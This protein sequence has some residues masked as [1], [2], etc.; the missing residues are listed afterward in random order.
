MIIVVIH[1]P[2]IPVLVHNNDQFI[3]IHGSLTKL[4]N[5]ISRNSTHENSQK[6]K[7][8]VHENN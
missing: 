6:K 4:I 1:I 8:K 5:Q 7:C 3:V 2:Q